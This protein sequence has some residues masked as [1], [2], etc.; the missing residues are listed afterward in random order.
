M[1]YLWLSLADLIFFSGKRSKC[2]SSAFSTF[3]TMF[4]KASFPGVLKQ[5]IIWGRVYTNQLELQQKSYL[6]D[7]CNC[8]H[9][10]QWNNTCGWA[11]RGVYNQL[12]YEIKNFHVI[13]AHL[14][15]L[16]TLSQTTNFRSIQTESVCKWQ[17]HIWW[18]WQKVLQTQRKHHGKRRNFSLWAISPFPTVFS[19]DLYCRH[20]KKQGSHWKGLKNKSIA[21]RGQTQSMVH[22]C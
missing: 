6:F 18:K 7:S 9:K 8:H 20:E 11:N 13:W 16:L 4:S 21:C 3:P 15:H 14:Y 10:N 19:N 12:K 22:A 2:Y 17:F 1:W 5:V